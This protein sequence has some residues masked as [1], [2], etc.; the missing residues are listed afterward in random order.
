M[1]PSK[2]DGFIAYETDNGASNNMIRR[3]SCAARALY[4]FLPEDKLLTKD[5]LQQ[6]R[7]NLEERGY[8]SITVQNYVKYINRYL[9]FVGCTDIRFNRGRARDIKGMTFGYLT[10]L[11]P[12]GAKKRKNIVWRCQCKCGNIVEIPATCLLLGNTLSCGCLHKEHFQRIN[13]YIN[14]TSLRQVLEE[15]VVSTRSAS[16]YVGVTPK[17]WK[18][19]AYICYKKRR[20]S[21]GCYT[22]IEDAVKARAWGKELVQADAMGLLNFYEEIH[23]FDPE[24]PQRSM[25]SRKEFPVIEWRE[26]EGLGKMAKRRDNHS[27]CTGVLRVRNQWKV[28]ISQSG[29]R[30]NLGIFETFEEA[31]KARKQAEYDFKMEPESCAKKYKKKYKHYDYRKKK[32][33]P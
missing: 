32:K 25:L 31:V 15:Q 30:Y 17:R 12:T 5:R 9:D 4:D 22:D 21:L 7:K 14:N 18:W 29:I 33:N 19:Q 23:K 27:G 8:A 28:Q 1:S 3:I 26:N 13:K 10:A 24:L 2:I 11:E 20:Y 6:W 16:G